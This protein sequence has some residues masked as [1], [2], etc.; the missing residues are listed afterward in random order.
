[1]AR[2]GKQE[3]PGQADMH[4]QHLKKNMYTTSAYTENLDQTKIS[5]ALYV[6]GRAGV[7][8]IVPGRVR[9]GVW[10]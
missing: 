6:Q 10:H 1:M 7:R 5:H 9:S 8:S 3:H 4:I 2:W